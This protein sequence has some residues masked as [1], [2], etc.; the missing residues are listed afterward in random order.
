MTITVQTRHPSQWPTNPARDTAA[1]ADTFAAALASSQRGRQPIRFRQQPSRGRAE[2]LGGYFAQ[3]GQIVR[4]Q[5]GPP[6][7]DPVGR[8]SKCM[9]LPN[10]QPVVFSIA[11]MNWLC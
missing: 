3:P 1:A 8:G 5:R 7:S 11:L 6:R 4:V 10:E 2:L 9:A